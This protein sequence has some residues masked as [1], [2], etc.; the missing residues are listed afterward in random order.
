MRKKK[1]SQTVGSSNKA[2]PTRSLAN[3]LASGRKKK[4]INNLENDSCSEEEFSD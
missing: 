3:F 1:K 4:N 2:S